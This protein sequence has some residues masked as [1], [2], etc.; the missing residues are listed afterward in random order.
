ML[1]T[2]TNQMRETYTVGSIPLFIVRRITGSCTH[3]KLPW[4]LRFSSSLFASPF[5]RGISS[6]SNSDF[7]MCQLDS[8]AEME[9]VVEGGDLGIV[10]EDVQGFADG[11]FGP[12]PEVDTVCIFPKTVGRLVSAKTRVI[13]IVLLISWGIQS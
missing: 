6:Y 4:R 13:R 1:V 8:D 2:T 10:G 12:A 7:E 3:R 9:E 5:L 11:S